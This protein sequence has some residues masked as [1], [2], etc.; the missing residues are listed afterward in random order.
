MNLPLREDYLVYRDTMALRFL[1]LIAIFVFHGGYEYGYTFPNVGYTC[2]AGFY[3]LSGFGLE[4]SVRNKNGYLQNFLQ[5]RVFSIL[6]QFWVI[7]AVASLVI[8]VMY[9]D[10]GQAW[11]TL[12]TALFRHPVWFITE[13]LVFYVL[14]FFSCMFKDVRWKLL[15]LFVSSIATML[16]M[17][18]YYNDNLYIKSGMGFVLGVVWATYRNRIDEFLRRHYVSVMLISI[19]VL[20]TTFRSFTNIGDVF[21]CGMTCVFSMV[22]LC[23]ACM[24]D[25]KK[26][27]YVPLVLLVVGLLLWVFRQDSGMHTEGS[28]MIFFAA[29][30]TICYSLDK[31]QHV[32][33]FWGAMSFEFYIM[34][35]LPQKWLYPDIIS[36][37]LLSFTCAFV[38][39]LVLTYVAWRVT[40]YVLGLYNRGL[41]SFNTATASERTGKRGPN[42]EIL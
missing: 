42:Q 27:W 6:I 8:L 38:L 32:L 35:F 19:I 22:I 18:E 36:N 2:V 11:N 30:S 41:E 14:F 31:F 25:A 26:G 16:M 20:G 4:Y 7:E 23:Q 13:L 29:V 33:A 9:L 24:V 34:H 5:K 21:I 3:F 28:F 17:A 1:L 12:L 40:R 10:V 39:S 37:V 15:F